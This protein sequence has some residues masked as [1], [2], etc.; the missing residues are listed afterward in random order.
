MTFELLRYIFHC[1]EGLLAERAGW[2]AAVTVDCDLVGFIA[3]LQ[4]VYNSYFFFAK[5]DVAER[6]GIISV[7]R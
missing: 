3:A 7:V 5:L 1:I 2:L 6:T 4:V